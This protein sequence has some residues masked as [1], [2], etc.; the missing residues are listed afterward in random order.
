MYVN[1]RQNCDCGSPVYEVAFCNDCNEPHLL[2]RDKKGKLVQWENKGGDEFSLQD[3]V[4]VE[5]D[6]TEEKVE[7]ENSF[8]PPLIIAAGETSE[9][10]YTLQRLDRQTRRIGVINNDSIPLIINDIEQVCSASG[11]GYRGMSGKQP[12]RRALLGGPFYVT[13]IVPTVLEYCQDFTSD[14]GK[15]GV[16]P[17]SLPGRGRRLITFTDSRQGTAR[18]A[19]R[20]QQEAERSRLRGSVVEILS[21]HQR[22][23]TS[24]APNANADLEKL[25]ARAK[26]AREQAEEYRSWGMPDQAKL[27]QAQAEQLEQAY[28]AA[29][30]GKA[31]TILVSRTWT[32][33]VNELKERADIRGPV[34]QYNHYLKPEVFN[35]NGGPLKL[36]EML[37]F[38]EFMR[39]PKRTNSLETQGLVQVG[40]Q[41]LEKIHKSP[42]HW[43]EKGLTLDDWRDFLK[44]TLDHYVRE[45]N[46]TQLDDE[47]KNWIGSRF[48]SKF[49]RNPESK[50]PEDNQNRRWPQ[51]RNGNVSHRLAKLLMLGAGFKTVNAA[52]IDIINT[53]L[54]EA[55]AQLTGPLAVLK[56]DG[57]R[58]YLPKEHMTF[59]LI[60]D[61]W[62]CPVTNKILDT[63][64]KGLTPYLP[65][66]ISFE[67]L[68]LAQYDTFVAQKVTMPEIWKLDRSQEDYAEGL[69]KARDWVSHDPLIAQL[70]SENVWTDINDRV[71]E[72]GFYYRTAEHSAQQSSERLQS[73]EK[74]FKNGQLNVLNCSTTMEMGV[75]TDRVMTLASRSQQA[76]IPGPE[77]HL[78]D[79]LVV[80][81]LG[82]KTVE[83]NEFILPA[84]ATNAVERV[85]DIQIHKQLNGPLSQFGQRFWDV[86][87]NDH[88]EAQSLMN[89][90]RITGVH[91]TDRYLQ[92]PVALALLGSILRPLKTKL[93]DGAE[94][95]LDTLF[96]DKDRPGNRPFHDWMS[97]ADFQDFA[98]QWFAAALGRP[99]ELTVFDSPRDIP[100]HRKLTVTFEDGQVLKIRFDQGMG[101]WRI[102]FSSQWHYFDFRDDVSFQLVKMAQAC[103]EGNVANSEESW[104]TDVL[105]EVIA[106]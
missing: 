88:E 56:P 79:E 86:L 68:T 20:M 71:V 11:C 90:T 28:Q 10:G 35:E 5:H 100:H 39:R 45:S 19:V 37:L 63:A 16:G 81:S 49:V 2:A 6:A 52:T 38:R 105:V 25:A 4:P 42:L 102:N 9:A 78:N 91:Y 106:S 98:D 70:R 18:M 95:T 80:R 36:S 21:W 17:D 72:G 65:T 26:Q 58:F 93:T 54:K 84:K 67:H 43:Q 31:A 40:Y 103:K 22:T 73:Y 66:H 57:N 89:N 82:Y 47:L 46:F 53:W 69:A 96:K 55:W 14:E 75:D 50:D 48:S 60:T 34:L 104:A 62:I 27:S 87:F 7:K 76:T 32:E 94:V 3:E 59:S 61:A 24:T 12:F 23:Q 15:E 64:F 33:M 29:T 41:G 8:Q 101:Y 1:Q 85:K 97:I 30:G 92:N 83:L 51:I 99:V 74:M 44:V 77:W 13:N